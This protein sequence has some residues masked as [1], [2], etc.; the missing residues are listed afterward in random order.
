MKKLSLFIGILIGF[1]F[2]ESCSKENESGID[3]NLNKVIGIW[4]PVKE[5]EIYVD[6]TIIENEYDECI[7]Q[8]RF[9]F[10]ENGTLQIKE[11]AKDEITNICEERIEPVLT[12]GNWEETN[13]GYRLITTYTYTTNQQSFTDDG[14]PEIFTLSNN[15]TSLRIGYADDEIING[16][17]LEFYY[18]DFVK[19]E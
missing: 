3:E 16:N 10:L 14:I 4:K 13:D 19:I 6:Q 18:T 2:L 1:L 17:Q 5:G 15:N 11:F 7:Q 8:G 12:L 9:T